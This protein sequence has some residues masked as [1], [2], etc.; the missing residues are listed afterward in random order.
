MKVAKYKVVI[1]NFG[2]YKYALLSFLSSLN[3]IE[4]MHIQA[5]ASSP[6]LNDGMYL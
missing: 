1:N 3:T 2:S 5:V 4:T 6:L